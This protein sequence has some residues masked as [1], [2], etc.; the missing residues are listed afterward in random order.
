MLS[1]SPRSRRCNRAGFVER[2]SATAKGEKVCFTSPS[3]GSA[4]KA[5]VEGA[6]GWRSEMIC[7]TSLAKRFLKLNGR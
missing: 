3:T 7:R 2:L 1:R 4:V 5:A 6:G